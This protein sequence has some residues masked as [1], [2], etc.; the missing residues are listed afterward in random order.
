[1]QPLKL[2]RPL[3]SIDVETT[4]LSITRDRITSLAVVIV[5]GENLHRR[6]SRWSGSW[7]FNPGIPI[8]AE[9]TELTGITN[10]MVKDAPRFE[11]KA[12]EILRVLDG[13]DLAGY[14]L[15]R[16]DIP[17]LHEHFSRAGKEWNVRSLNVIDV[18]ELFQ[19]KDP[20]TLEAAVVKFCG[21]EHVGAHDSEN[22]ATE[23]L[24]V[25]VGIREWFTELLELD[26]AG[27]AKASQRDQFVDLAG[28][29]I[30]GKDGRP[31]FSF[32]E[33]T[34]GMAVEDDYNNSEPGRSFA[35]WILRN[36]FPT[37][38]KQVLRG[39]LDDLEAKQIQQAERL[40]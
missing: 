23:T 24:E 33:R 22:D 15:R 14:N 3:A 39:I 28:K 35:E 25:L 31:A 19:I 16:F 6:F 12:D 30:V 40:M 1:M 27:L 17:I 4:G 18:G 2:T 5:S 38:T 32:G 10:E 9:I 37:H 7:L 29:I 26:A 11:E 20:R 34:K 36:D 21:R 13:C 8:S